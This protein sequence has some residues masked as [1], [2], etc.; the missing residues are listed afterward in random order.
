MSFYEGLVKAVHPHAATVNTSETR[1]PKI[2]QEILSS[3]AAPGCDG[4]F[5]EYATYQDLTERC[6]T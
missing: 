4:H 3:S 6:D 2:D 5:S 1:T